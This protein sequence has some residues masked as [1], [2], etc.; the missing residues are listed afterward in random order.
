MQQQQ[1]NTAWMHVK[2]RLLP[3]FSSDI[4][5]FAPHSASNI[6]RT[7]MHIKNNKGSSF[8]KKQKNT[9]IKEICNKGQWPKQI[10]EFDISREQNNI[11]SGQRGISKE[12]RTAQRGSW[13]A[14]LSR[15]WKQ[16]RLLSSKKAF[17]LTQDLASPSEGPI[18]HLSAVSPL[19][20]LLLYIIT[21]A[22]YNC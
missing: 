2:Q 5:Y 3:N 15:G 19:K 11:S 9:F 17:R 10:V 14:A 16:Q 20:D 6:L 7:W 13:W 1:I 12:L 8:K 4:W 22:S 21:H 18:A